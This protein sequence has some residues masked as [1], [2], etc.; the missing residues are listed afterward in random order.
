MIPKVPEE[1][2]H[3]RPSEETIK[4]AIRALLETPPQ[5]IMAIK[6]ILND[7]SNICRKTSEG[8]MHWGLKDSKDYVEQVLMQRETT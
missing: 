7:P 5:R 3:V 2:K 6:I 8:R 4:A 1:L